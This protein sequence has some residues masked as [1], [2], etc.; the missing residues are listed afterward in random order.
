MLRYLFAL[1]LLCLQVILIN[2]KDLTS[3]RLKLTCRLAETV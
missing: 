2:T 1:Q 3:A